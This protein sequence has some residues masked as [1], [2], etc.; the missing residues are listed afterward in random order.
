MTPQMYTL[1]KMISKMIRNTTK[2]TTIPMNTAVLI[3]IC[4]KIITMMIHKKN[5]Y[6]PLSN[7]Y[8]LKTLYINFQN[9][10]IIRWTG[11]TLYADQDGPKIQWEG[12]CLHLAEEILYY[13]DYSWQ[14]DNISVPLFVTRHTHEIK[15]RSWLGPF[16]TLCH[17]PD[18]Y[19]R[20]HENFCN[21]RIQCSLKLDKTAAP[22]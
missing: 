11:Y 3:L 7:H 17:D 4:H 15:P 13:R 20:R 2:K 19:E 14:W 1:V 9:D 22:L 8:K 21:R 10:P 5:T 12:S 16:D 6:I 18:I